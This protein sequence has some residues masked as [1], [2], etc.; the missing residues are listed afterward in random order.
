MPNKN[1]VSSVDFYNIAQGSYCEPGTY[2][3]T[4]TSK[5][6]S[7]DPGYYCPNYLMLSPINQ[8]NAGFY[9]LGSAKVPTPKD[10]ITGNI[11]PSGNYCPAGTTSAMPCPP[12][13]YLGYNGA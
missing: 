3:P 1:L 12:S 6:V 5:A 2:C 11:C 4:G 9:C 10:G 13:T 8:C 7:C